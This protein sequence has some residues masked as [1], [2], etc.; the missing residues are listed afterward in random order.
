MAAINLVVS[1]AKRKTREPRAG[2]RLRVV[3]PGKAVE[4]RAAAWAARLRANST[5]GVPAG[6]LY[7]GEHWHTVRSVI[8]PPTQ[9]VRVWVVSAGYGLVRLDTPLAP[10][11][12]T[13]TPGQADSVSAAGGAT[14]RTALPTWWKAVAELLAP[15]LGPRKLAAVA[16]AHPADF[17]L[18]ALPATYLS[19]VA[20]DLADAVAV[21][22]SHERLAV[23]SAG[24]TAHEAIAPY[25]L[26]VNGR[27]SG[28]A[29]GTMNAINARLARR[30]IEELGHEPLTLARCRAAVAGWHHQ[31]TDPRAPAR[32]RA[33][34]GEV[35]DFIRRRL[36]TDGAASPTALLRQL[37]DA[38]TACGQS[39][40]VALFRRA[41]GGRRAR[42]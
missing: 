40:F 21:L 14:M 32:C 33:T 3:R 11:S 25:L 22:G 18:V 17:L 27:L 15:H 8:G 37:R 16:A 30:L 41:G 4:S 34:D 7:A 2:L 36:A 35:G 19:A 26:P 31:A 39:R 24:G 12:A 5:A 13:F 10:Y 28:F 42:G 23:L 20:L 29:G 9:P 38:G 1:C 6:E